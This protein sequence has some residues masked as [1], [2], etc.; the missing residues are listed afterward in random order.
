MRVD[1]RG[2]L[3][4]RPVRI[5]PGYMKY[6][7]GSALIEV[8]DT[9]VI[10]TASVEDRVPQFLKGELPRG[11]VTAEYSML[12]RSARTRIPR[13]VSKGRV[14]GRTSEIQRLIGRALR[15]VVD[16]ESLG[17]RTI[18]IDCDVVQADGGT[19]T[20]AI[21]GGFVALAQAC[22]RLMME[23]A[24][25]KWA[26]RDFVGAVSV[27][28]IGGEFLLD[29]CYEEDSAADVDM[30]VV[31]TSTGG[32]VEIQGTAEGMTFSRE[33]LEVMISIAASGIE[34]LIAVQRQ[35]LEPVLTGIGGV[36]L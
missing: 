31:M 2:A 22:Y 15:A 10:C 1:G 21:T 24:V 7:E 3:D 11:W 14:G 16:L 12:P 13:E 4:L 33:E 36:Q 17:E 18:C 29:L 25:E 35:V 19:R 34:K 20:A 26:I 23:G 30:N 6:A 32:L 5:V 28:K 9:K 27:G 8:G